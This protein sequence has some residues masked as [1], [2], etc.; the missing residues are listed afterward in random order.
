MDRKNLL[1]FA[2]AVVLVVAGVVVMSRS[3]APGQ[4]PTAPVTGGGEVS[5]LKDLPSYEPGKPRVTD[6]PEELAEAVFGDREPVLH[7]VEIDAAGFSPAELTVK[8]G[9]LVNWTNQDEA[10]HQIAGSGGKWGSRVLGN[11]DA[12]TQEFDVDGVYDYN[13][14]LDPEMVG[15]IIVER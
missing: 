7:Q 11:G 2:A 12:F 15:K 6:I 9:D 10:E 4:G 5:D 8:I 13:C 3:S 1:A 14:K